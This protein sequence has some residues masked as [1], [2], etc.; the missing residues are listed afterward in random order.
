MQVA[1][2]YWDG[3]LSIFEKSSLM[4]FVKNNFRVNLWTYSSPE[5]VPNGVNVKD[6]NEILDESWIGKYVF[7]D[8]SKSSNKNIYTLFSDLFRV[9][10]VSEGHGWWFDLDC[11]CLK[12]EKYFQELASKNIF[13][14]GKE[15]EEE[16]NASVLFISEES[17]AK[18][19]SKYIFSTAKSSEDRS[20]GFTGPRAITKFLKDRNLFEMS[21][22]PNTFYPIEYQNYQ[23]AYKKEE[24]TNCLNLTKDSYVY[25]WWSSLNYKNDESVFVNSSSI[26][27]KKMEI[28]EGSYLDYLFKSLEK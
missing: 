26:Q 15:N 10:L 27:N 14:M 17:F 21:Q 19:F 8:P 7:E 3:N 16:V 11:F 2:F 23:D 28:E 9:K 24:M 20:Y 22:K 6:A 5:D 4:S 13:V 18:K 1:N 12:D 25:H